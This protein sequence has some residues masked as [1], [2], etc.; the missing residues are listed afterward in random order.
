MP[1]T[2]PIIRVMA[3]FAALVA[4]I[5]QAASQDWPTRPVTMVFP[6]AAGSAGDVLGRIFASH[7]SDLLGQPV[8]FEN[9]GGAGGMTGA[10]R[11][12]KAAPDGYQFMLGGT[13]M[14]LNQTLYKKPLY[15]AA[16]DFA[17]VA[18]VADQPLVL[19]VRK[20]LPVSNLQEFI[21]YA[22]VNQAKMQYASAGMGSAPHLACELLN[23]AIGVDV[24]HVPYRGGGA[25][26]QDLIAGRVDYQ[27]P[28][29]TIALPQIEGK[30]VKAI[31]ILSKQRL[32]LL[33]ELASAYEQGATRFDF[34][35]WFAFFL[36]KGTPAPI[37]RK[38]HDA[39]TATME[40]PSVQARLKETGATLV[41]PERRSPEYLQGFVTREIEKFAGP[42]KARGVEI[43]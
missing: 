18:L 21:A 27:C 29:S 16:S 32:P 3:A 12:A 19:I 40:M 14:A 35:F 20:D 5:T 15:N 7:L 13:F 2:M 36:P 42:I 26:M 37:V 6:F 24:V 34:E 30:M 25:A 22:K 10:N 41:V 1:S 28:V 9:V 38:L 31:A 11:V 23:G 8:I 43:E 39:I 17:P 33:P 4:T